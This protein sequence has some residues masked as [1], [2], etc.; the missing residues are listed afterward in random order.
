MNGVKTMRE[1]DEE[2]RGRKK[3]KEEEEGRR[4]GKKRKEEE[5]ARRGGKK[6]REGRGSWRTCP[7]IFVRGSLA[8]HH[9]DESSRMSIVEPS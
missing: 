3:S 1:G 6:R 4:G 2:R 9:V 5:E 7:S 8:F